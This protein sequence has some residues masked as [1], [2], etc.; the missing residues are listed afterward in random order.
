M[1]AADSDIH[2]GRS[3]ADIG[4][5][6][7]DLGGGDRVL[8]VGRSDM[9][10]SRG[11]DGVALGVDRGRSLVLSRGGRGG[12]GLGVDGGRSLVLGGRGGDRVS[13]VGRSRAGGSVGRSGAG[14]VDGVVLR[15]GLGANGADGS[16]DSERTHF[17]CEGWD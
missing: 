1:W 2:N 7:D 17:D 4:G 11:R 12:V 10:G 5:L 8:G 14:L 15:H 16:D 3:G 6:L 9:V 13:V